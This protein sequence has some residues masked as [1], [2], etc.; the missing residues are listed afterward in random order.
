MN[1]KKL[2]AMEKIREEY[3][4]LE[5]NSPGNL[6][7]SLAL[8]DNNIFKWEGGLYGPKQTPYNDGF[9]LFNITFT[10]NYPEEAPEVCFTTPIYHIN[11]NPIKG[12]KNNQPLG[13][14]CNSIL[15]WWNPKSNMRNLLNN[16]FSLFFMANP[17]I[18]YG[19]EIAK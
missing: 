11:I 6:G 5:E 10:E 3:N 2:E 9:F 14:A 4:D 8:D 19:S 13:F 1:S 16:I 18:P 7:I 15:N 17:E 12:G